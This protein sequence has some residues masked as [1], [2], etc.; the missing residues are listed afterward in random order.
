MLNDRIDNL[1]LIYFQFKTTPKQ[2]GKGKRKVKEIQ[3]PR[4]DFLL[5]KTTTL[6]ITEKQKQGQGQH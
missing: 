4:V 6:K 1:V 3:S 2:K 5:A